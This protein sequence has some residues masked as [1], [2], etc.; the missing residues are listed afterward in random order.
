MPCSGEFRPVEALSKETFM[1]VTIFRIYY[2]N[3]GHMHLTLIT[4]GLEQLLGALYIETLAG[5]HAREV[6]LHKT[7]DRL[8]LIH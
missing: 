4:D 8:A 1:F 2:I 6:K 3:S 5:C 7:L